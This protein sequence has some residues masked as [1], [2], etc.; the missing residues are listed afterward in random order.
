M[1]HRKSGDE[2]KIEILEAAL[3][4][5]DDLGPDRLTTDAIARE[6]GLTQ[7]GIFRHF[8][9][10]QAIWDAV[11]ATIADRMVA[12]WR[13]VLDRPENPIDRLKGLIIAQL[14]LIEST[15]A[16]TAILFSREL[17]AR[18]DMLRQAIFKLMGAFHAAVASEF[19]Q[20]QESRQLRRDLAADDAAFLLIGLVQG[21]AV[22]WSLSG[23][24]FTLTDEGARLLNLQIGAFE[25]L[26][27]D[28]EISEKT[29]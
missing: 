26:A 11:V 22:R 17:H 28:L 21:L 7:P 23:R 4:L 2:R 25:A 15:P 20:A 29:S 16:I 3:R 14:R 12:G 24:S 5:A 1:R 18:N 19:A 9:T 8:P 27:S 6:V 13:A 10:K